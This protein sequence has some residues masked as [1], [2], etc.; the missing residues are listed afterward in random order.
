MPATNYVIPTLETERLVLRPMRMEDWPRYRDL[1]QSDRAQ[2]MGGPHTLQNSWG[3]F[4]HDMAQWPLMG[5]GS[6]MIELRET[7]VCVGQVS[8]NSGPLFP[9]TELGWYLYEEAEGHGYGK[10]AATALRSWAF[11]M[12]GL[13]TLVS[14][15]EPENIRSRA[16]AERLG[17]VPDEHAP[18][19]DPTDLVYRHTKSG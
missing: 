18:R 13:E 11:D 5:H 8:I 2:Y 15:I 19:P 1:M 10:E 16:L 9:E 7:G 6:L 3:M 14:Y 17:V 12:L 4:C